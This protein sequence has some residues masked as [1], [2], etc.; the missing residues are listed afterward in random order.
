MTVAKI[1]L[2]A[3]KQDRLKL[4]LDNLDYSTE[5]IYEVIKTI[6]IDKGWGPDELIAYLDNYIAKQGNG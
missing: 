4:A 5:D 6:A 3:L 2:R 1:I